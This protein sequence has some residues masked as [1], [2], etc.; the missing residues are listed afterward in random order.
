[1]FQVASH[2]HAFPLHAH[3]HHQPMPMSTPS[4]QLPRTLS[5]PQFAEVSRESVVA[6]AP[7]LANVPAEYIRRGLRAK[8]PQYVQCCHHSVSRH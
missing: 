1:M 8:A 4:V 2:P 7:E 6:V 3:G 5:R